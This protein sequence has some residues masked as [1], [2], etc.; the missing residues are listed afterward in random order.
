MLNAPFALARSGDFF[1]TAA[2]D[3][4]IAAGFA[5]LA[6]LA[7]LLLMRFSRFGRRWRAYADDPLGAQLLGVDPSAVFGQTF[8]LASGFAGLS[9]CVMTLYYGSVGYAA[10][11]TLGLKALVAA[12]LGGVG[13]V[14]GAFVGGLVV[15][16]YEAI[17][18]SYF[19]IDYRDV[20]TFSLLAIVLALRPGG[21][22]GARP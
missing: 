19:P 20:A 21:L 13:S 11:T 1:V 4:L 16:A 17:W 18:S 15:G 14:P 5:F 6:G 12:I 8:A 22:F 2:P 9:G 10:A 7:L 3:A